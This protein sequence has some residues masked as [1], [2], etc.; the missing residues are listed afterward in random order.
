MPGVIHHVQQ[1][2][3]A[4]ISPRRDEEIE[5][6]NSQ[7]ELGSGATTDDDG[8]LQSDGGRE[9]KARMAAL[10]GQGWSRVQV[11]PARASRPGAT[12][13]GRAGPGGN[14]KIR[15]GYSVVSGRRAALRHVG[16]LK[17]AGDLGTDTWRDEFSDLE[18]RKNIDPV[19]LPQITKRKRVILV[20]HGQ[21][22]VSATTS[23]SPPFP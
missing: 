18:D 12:V 13:R 19:P 14:T 8:L 1:K 7:A 22:T 5:D 10:L 20:R 9:Y 16:A 15:G 11:K 21:S 2:Y 3:L 17:D 6:Y 4:E 23:P